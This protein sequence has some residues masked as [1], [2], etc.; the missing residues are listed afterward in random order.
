MTCRLIGAQLRCEPQAIKRPRRRVDNHEVDGS[1]GG[2]QGLFRIAFHNR[3]VLSGQLGRDPMGLPLMVVDDQN[4]STRAPQARRRPSDH[5]HAPSGSLAVPKLVDHHLKP[6]QAANPREQHHV[7]DGFGQKFI[8]P[9]LEPGNPIRSTVQRRH[10]H[11]RNVP[12]LGV[13]LQPSAHLEP[14]HPRHHDVQQDN[15]GLLRRRHRQGRG[16][17]VSGQNFIV[18]RAEL[19]LQQPH[20]RFNVVNHQDTSRHR[21]FQQTANSFKEVGDGDRLGYVSLATSLPDPFLV[22]FHSE[23]GD[24]HDR[25]RTKF[26]IFLQ[27]LCDL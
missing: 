15:V 25:D 10:Q 4:T 23:R 16:P 14:V 2:H 17:I 1:P 26:V 21:L 9:G 24:G 27:P 5:P 19:G 11:Y 3:A 8:S 12:G 6:G 18:F 7:I 22:T 20:I 13:V